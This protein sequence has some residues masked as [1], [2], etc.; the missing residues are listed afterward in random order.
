MLADLSGQMLVRK[1]GFVSE[2][3]ASSL[4]PRPT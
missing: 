4:V 3:A 2:A 1:V